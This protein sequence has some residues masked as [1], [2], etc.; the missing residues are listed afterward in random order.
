MTLSASSLG[1]PPGEA[2]VWTGRPH[3]DTWLAS[4]VALIAGAVLAVTIYVGAAVARDSWFLIAI[5]ILVGGAYLA[6]SVRLWR[7]TRTTYAVTERYLYTRAPWRSS[8]IRLTALPE[9]QVVDEAG[10]CGTIRL[11]ADGEPPGISVLRWITLS[12]DVIL[13][14]IEDPDAVRQRMVDLRDRYGADGVAGV[15]DAIPAP[16]GA[17]APVWR[18]LSIALVWVVLGGFVAVSWVTSG[19]TPTFGP[20]PLVAAASILT[21]IGFAV[22]ILRDRW[23]AER[24]RS[25]GQLAY[26][27]VTA[28]TSEEPTGSRGPIFEIEYR[29]EVVGRDYT[30]K[31]RELSF[32]QAHAAGVGDTILIRYDPSRPERSLWASG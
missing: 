8:V 28:I 19:Q 10:G 23:S 16:Q 30:G 3:A 4:R 14:R 29:Y 31:T 5:A 6:V 25:T 13:W 12:P 26:A 18:V 17:R 20:V 11:V 21:G 7:L 32:E 2:I 1:V 27:R 24:L 9:L 22:V 15:V